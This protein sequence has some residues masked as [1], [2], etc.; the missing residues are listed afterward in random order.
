MMTEQEKRSHRCCFTGH[1][2]QKLARSESAIISDM[3][4]AILCAIQQGYTTFISGMAYGVDIWAG[5]IVVHLRK[6]NP[7]L[8]LIAAVPYP[9]FQSRWPAYWKQKYNRLLNQSDL[10][11]YIS[12]YYHT[13]AFQH[14]NEWLVDHSGLVIAVYRGIPSGTKNTIEYAQSRSVPVYF[15]DG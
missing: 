5:E 2:P 3:E 6:G 8:H 10:V 15:I 9:D 4:T 11:R 7:A 12:P 14:R 1:R 13:G